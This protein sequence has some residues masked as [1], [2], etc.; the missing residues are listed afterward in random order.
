MFVRGYLHLDCKYREGTR[1]S[2]TRSSP[3]WRAFCR[4]FHAETH[5]AREVFTLS[6]VSIIQ[7]IFIRI[8]AT[9][10]VAPGRR[11]V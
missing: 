4:D 6:R 2:A 9:L 5:I 10:R 7:R 1:R 11:I 3:P 8:R